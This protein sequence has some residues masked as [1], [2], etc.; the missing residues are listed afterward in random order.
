MKETP[1]WTVPNLIDDIGFKV[2]VKGTGHVFARGRL[3][4][5]CAEA[6]IIGRRRSL[7]KTSIGL[8]VM[9]QNNWYN[10]KDRK[11]YSH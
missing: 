5:K 6:T 11:C 10:V 4:K 9:V 3:R 7:E 1:V 2:D 8:D